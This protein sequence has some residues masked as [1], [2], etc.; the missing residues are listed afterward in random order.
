MATKETLKSGSYWR[1]KLTQFYNAAEDFVTLVQLTL[2]RSGEELRARTIADDAYADLRA[3]NLYSQEGV[4]AATSVVAGTT[5]ESG[6]T[7]TANTSFILKGTDVSTGFGLWTRGYV[8]AATTFAGG[9]TEN[10]AVQVP[11]GA[12]IIACQ[13]R[14]DTIIVSSGATWSAAY[15]TG[16]TQSIATGKSKAK[17]TKASTFFDVN[18]ATAIASAATDIT[19][20]PA[21]G[22][23]TSGAISAV[24]YYEILTDL[25]SL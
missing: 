3:K 20:T 19:I 4:S 25:T 6:T 1:D 15:N 9:A 24:V 13:L 16:A 7:N 17:N 21:S 18:A 2:Q 8:T 10:I 23:L 12:K 5:I 11:S 22:T 14:A